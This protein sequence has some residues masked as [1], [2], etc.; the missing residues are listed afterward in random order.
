MG[1]I[2]SIIFLSMIV[3][4][5]FQNCNGIVK[6]QPLEAAKISTG[7]PVATGS[8]DPESDDEDD[9]TSRVLPAVQMKALSVANLELPA[10]LATA[11]L[12][13]A[14]EGVALQNGRLIWW[15]RSAQAGTHSIE[16]KVAEKIWT[17]SLLV[18]PLEGQDQMAGP[19]KGFSDEDVGYIFIHGK[20]EMDLCNGGLARAYWAGGDAIIAPIAALRTVTCY[21]GR[22]DVATEAAKI[23]QQILAAPCG[24]LNRCIIVTHSMGG[25]MIEHILTH[26]RAAAASDPPEYRKHYDSNVA[27][28]KVKDRIAFVISLASAAGGS[29]VADMVEN[30]TTYSLD[31]S[32]MGAIS[33]IFGAR[34]G[35][36]NN[37]VPKFAVNVAAPMTAN[38]GVP[39]YLVAGYSRQL[40]DIGGLVGGPSDWLG[41]TDPDKRVF[42]ADVSYG[43]LDYMTGFSSRSDGVV[44]FRSSCGI[45]SDRMDDGP[46]WDKELSLQFNYCYSATKKP[47]HFVWFAINLNHSLIQINTSKCTNSDNPCQ[48]YRPDPVRKTMVRDTALDQ[49]SSVEI[50]RQHLRKL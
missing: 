44:S 16:L 26:T 30:P 13:K 19:P 48:I 45:A 22:N 10:E 20:S 7:Q 46:G 41:I 35:S 9:P 37:L 43:Y 50:I 27:Y 39:I 23:T 8:P 24:K 28:S 33:R 4:F 12:Q 49:K 25:L 31:Q 34:S 11:Q 5:C 21:D 18:E 15:P 2:L 3:I 17:L 40:L 32:S 42:N 38:P 6:L 1:K 36:T 47:N 29:K 14:P